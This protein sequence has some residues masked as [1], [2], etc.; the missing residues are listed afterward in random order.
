MDRVPFA[1][2]AANFNKR[3]RCGMAVRLVR[4]R[5]ILSDFLRARCVLHC[6]A[7]VVHF[8][9]RLARAAALAPRK[10]PTVRI[11]DV[12]TG[13]GDCIYAALM[14]VPEGQLRAVAIDA[15]ADLFRAMRQT[16]AVNRL[17]TRVSSSTGNASHVVTRGVAAA[18]PGT[19]RV[20]VR[21]QTAS[22]EFHRI[23]LASTLD[24]ELRGLGGDIHFLKMFVNG[25]ELQALH[26]ATELL[27]SQRIRCLSIR[28]WNKTS[29]P[30]ITHTAEDVV[31]YLGKFGYRVERD[32]ERAKLYAMPRSAA[33]E[34]AADAS[35]GFESEGELDFALCPA[36]VT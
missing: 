5:H 1:V 33:V 30:E 23:V 32:L 4:K 2:G 34:D 17:G 16:V 22:S 14:L 9:D 19:R 20:K 12:G 10:R 18:P 11:V 27:A 3:W 7:S 28:L 6:P 21:T 13:M 26:G 15:D 36:E 29:D 24:A 25:A 35:S 8:L 31:R